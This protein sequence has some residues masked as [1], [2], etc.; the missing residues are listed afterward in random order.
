MKTD[1]CIKKIDKYLTSNDAQPL[2]V[3]IQNGSD[4]EEIL[5]HFDVEGN[6]ILNASEFCNK[7]QL[8][9]METVLS[10]ISTES[11][12][13]FLVGLTSFLRLYGE[14]KLKT[15]LTDIVNMFISG[16]VI[17]LTYQ[18]YNLLSF[19]DPRL[20]RRIFVCDGDPTPFPKLSFVSKEL[21]T[22]STE[23]VVDG[24]DKIAKE[25]ENNKYS[26]IYVLTSMDK[27]IFSKSVY[28]ISSMSKAFEI[29]ITKDNMLSSLDESIGTDRQWTYL[30][31]LLNKNRRFI[32]ICD[33][34]FENHQNLE[35]AILKYSN[36]T[37]NEKWLY[38]IG[39]KLFGVKNN[40]YL[41]LAVNNATNHSML[42]REIYRG[43]LS[44]AHTDKNF[45]KIYQK[46]KELLLALSNPI[47]EVIDFCK[48]VLQKEKNAIY[49]LT[50]N[51]RQEKEL[52]ITLITK[53]YKTEDKKKLE[54][55]LSMVYMDLCYYIKDYRYDQP[56]L[57]KYFSLYTHSKI[58]NNI[59]PELEELVNEQA[60]VREYNLLLEPRTTKIDTIYEENSLIY[61]IDSMGV[62]YLSYILAKCKEKGLMANVTICTAKLPSITSTNREFVDEFENKGIHVKPKKQLD[63]IKHHG[64]DDCDD[65][66]RK[67]PIHL[68]KELE[69]IDETLDEIKLQLAQHEY[70]K[71]IMVSDHGS[72]R[73]AVIHDNINI[74]EMDSKGEHA[75]RCCPKTDTDVQLP[76]AIEENGYWALAN[77]DR[78]RGG[79]KAN[80]EVHGGAT[81]EEVIVPIIEI[82][83]ITNDI[84]V[85]ILDEVITVSFRKKATIRLF[86]KT[87]LKNLTV[88]IEGI[89]YK[90]QELDNNIYQINMPQLKKAKHY[91]LDVYTSNNLIATGLKFEIK[92]E[93]SQEKDLL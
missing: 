79:R 28:T 83:R 88:C 6:L 75:G 52:I 36:Y 64:T 27:K 12:N 73:L 91:V 37:D 29:I 54:S 90:A 59:L 18:C 81:L 85:F 46:R 86:S 4:L 22:P 39:L 9:R 10:N 47:E 19:S 25:I 43:I 32:D 77:Y 70:G 62:E 42:I 66:K 56:L 78:F 35:I 16:H 3:D 14:E 2:L 82:T 45:K 17:V 20:S 87:K 15:H 41:A 49:Y 68:I 21:P 89:F 55:I 26:N 84:E 50:D 24:I 57:D 71:A 63:D 76:I 5:T 31:E 1:A 11:R 33:E 40:E 61:F 38:F 80:V 60:I 58:I 72:S 8:P 51:T 48:V 34:K 92:K 69:I 30:L 65:R 74:W 67:H 23:C 53:Y 93:S 7:D 13:C 44:Y